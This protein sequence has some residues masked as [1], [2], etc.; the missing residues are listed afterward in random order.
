MNF[1]YFQYKAVQVL[2][3]HSA[4]VTA[5][6]AVYVCAESDKSGQGRQLS[7]TIL[8]TASVDSTVKV[9]TRLPDQGLITSFIKLQ[10][11]VDYLKKIICH[12]W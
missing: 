3:G 10:Q 5:L 2:I 8:I 4:P 12:L 6:E 7:K 11:H 9:W 1:V